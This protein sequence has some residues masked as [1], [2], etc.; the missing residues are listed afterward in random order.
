MLSYSSVVYIG[1]IWRNCLT[2]SGWAPLR[3]GSST[4]HTGTCWLFLSSSPQES[5]EVDV[6]CVDAL[7]Y[8]VCQR[9]KPMFMHQV[10][11]LDVLGE[12]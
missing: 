2:V 12:V 9:L 6:S 5:V 1:G 7:A 11:S 3:R 8:N 4:L 10:M